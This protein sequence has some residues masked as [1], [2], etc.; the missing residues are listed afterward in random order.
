MAFPSIES[1]YQGQDR[2]LLGCAKEEAKERHVGYTRVS[3][4][5]SVCFSLCKT[6][7]SAYCV[8]DTG[9]QV[10]NKTPTEPSQS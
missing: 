7:S 10:G 5:L 2:L 4:E 3:A 6:L 9:D 8:P 1:Y